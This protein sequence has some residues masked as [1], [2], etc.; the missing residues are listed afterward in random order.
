L[1]KSEYL[2]LGIKLGLTA[3]ETLWLAP[4]IVFDI[5]ELKNREIRKEGP[6]QW[7]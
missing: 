2:N 1:K 3:A 4:G 6:E 5:L 7:Q